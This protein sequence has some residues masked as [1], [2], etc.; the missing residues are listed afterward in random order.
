MR[1]HPPDTQGSDPRQAS[2]GGAKLAQFGWGKDK[3]TSKQ[4]ISRL[5]LSAGK[6]FE[7]K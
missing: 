6:D 5:R 2:R 1:S 3:I 7:H 4:F